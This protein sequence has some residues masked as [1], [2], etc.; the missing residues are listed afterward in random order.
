MKSHHARAKSVWRSRTVPAAVYL[1]SFLLPQ[2]V[3]VLAADETYMV[4]LYLDPQWSGDRLSTS[5]GSGPFVGALAEATTW[6]FE[7]EQA[8][9]RQYIVGATLV[10]FEI[11]L[12]PGARLSV[13]ILGR[14]DGRI[15]S[16]GQTVIEEIDVESEATR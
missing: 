10:D 4:T 13:E 3:S 14:I 15:V 1:L 12:D 16:A 7:S 6:A 9:S 8:V 2:S 5:S 11:D